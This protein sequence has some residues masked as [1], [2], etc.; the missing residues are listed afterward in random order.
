MDEDTQTTATSRHSRRKQARTCFSKWTPPPPKKSER[1][2]SPE[3]AKKEEVE[4]MEIDEERR[5][6]A[7]AEEEAD[8]E[9]AVKLEGGEA[10]EGGEANEGGEKHDEAAK[11]DEETHEEVEERPVPLRERMSRVQYALSY[12][13]LPKA[14]TE[15]LFQDEVLYIPL[16]PT[17]VAPIAV[18]EEEEVSSGGVNAM[19]VCESASLSSS[20]SSSSSSSTRAERDAHFPQHSGQGREPA[21]ARGSSGALQQ[22]AHERQL[23]TRDYPMR[24]RG[25]AERERERDGAWSSASAATTRTPL[26]HTSPGLGASTNNTNTTNS[27][28]ASIPS[29]D[30]SSSSSAQHS[31][32][33][34]SNVFPTMNR[35]TKLMAIIGPL[36]TDPRASFSSFE[37]RQREQQQQQHSSGNTNSNYGPQSHAYQRDGYNPQQQ[38]YYSSGNQY[39]GREQSHHYQYQQQQQQSSGHQSQP[40]LAREQSSPFAP[41]RHHDAESQGKPFAAHSSAAS[42]SVSPMS[43]VENDAAALMSTTAHVLQT[44][45]GVTGESATASTQQ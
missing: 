5:D 40:H 4:G 42:S 8:G 9:E 30:A 11:G 22:M 10:K 25:E 16:E 6:E 20:S 45:D 43:S 1:K 35:P 38:Q 36:S 18:P 39:P 19:V 14:I 7:K 12:L 32:V 28:N 13:V 23:Q 27:S 41:P 29:G 2:T 15:G 34:R 21:Y 17:P 33:I 37:P 44:Q 31:N 26:Q 24:E 3:R